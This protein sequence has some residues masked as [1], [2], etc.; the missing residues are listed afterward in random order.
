MRDAPPPALV[1]LVGRLGLASP[2]Q[3][4]AVQGRVRRLARGLP[5]FEQVW[6]DALAQARVLTPFQA[7]E[8]N[9]G[10]ADTLSV[11]PY[12]LA[13]PLEML[14]WSVVYRAIDPCKGLDVRL[15]VAS[16][17]AD[18]RELQND[19]RTR[20]LAELARAADRIAC[21]W[22]EP[23]ESFGYCGDRLWAASAYSVG[24]S[25]AEWIVHHGRMPP[26]A[27]HEIARQMAAGLAACEIAGVVHGDVAARNLWLNPEGLS[28][29][30]APGLRA[31]VQP[32]ES[33]A[34]CHRLPET[35][36]YLAP[37]RIADGTPPTIASDIYACGAVWWHLL[38]GRPPIAGATGLAKM[39]AAAA[40]KI[41]EIAELAP[42]APSELLEVLKACLARDPRRRPATFAEIS[43]RLGPPTAAGEKIVSR[44]L[45]RA[46]QCR[47][48]LGQ[49]P[50]A[51]SVRSRV[52]RA[53]AVA[54][55]CLLV[56]V[57]G[58]WPQWQARLA[59]RFSELQATRVAATT[60]KAT[61][62]P[63]PAGART[64]AAVPSV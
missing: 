59:R 42:E 34:Q 49:A 53:G 45:E 7:G 38:A 39:Q 44:S 27:V 32:A 10:R 8:I 4:L 15:C 51:R 13:Q 16:P 19:D 37:E 47:L 22:I 33:Y 40:G 57:A 52:R 64:A 20:Q 63:Q 24:Q 62:A 3:V 2:A 48:R 26:A 50:E 41:P 43:A 56:V 54:I 1:E 23:I 6:V 18:G 12:V 11:G 55:G 29:L 5:R 58:T 31:I 28:R 30:V 46:G 17:G 61:A 35:Y 60:S 21:S 14:G 9:A 25:S 36:D